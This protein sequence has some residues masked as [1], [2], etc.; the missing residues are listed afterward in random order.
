MSAPA[1]L[2]HADWSVHPGKRWMAQ[3]VR[4]RGGGYIA[5][6][7]T[8]VGALEDFWFRLGQMGR[9]G[10]ILAGFDFP[11]GLPATYAKQAGIED[12]A[13]ALAG[14]GQGR[15]RD[16]Y[17]VAAQPKHRAHAPVLSGSARWAI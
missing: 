17:E 4:R 12:F 15:W 13:T 14:F 6:P 7:P 9:D 11:I 3:A 16:F 8:P 2:V 1:L 5:L 10:P